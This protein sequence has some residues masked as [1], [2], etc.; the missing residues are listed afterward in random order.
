MKRIV[1]TLPLALALGACIAPPMESDEPTASEADELTVCPA[2]ATVSGIDTSHWQGVIDWSKVKAS[3][4]AFAIARVSD[5]VKY[6]DKNFPTDWPAIKAAGL[7]RGAYQFFRPA[8][9]PVAQADLLIQRLQQYGPLGPGDLPA[10]LDVETAD[11]MPNA[12]VRQNM[13]IWLDRVELHTGK[14]PIV[15]TAA[16]MSSVV[17]SGFS[18]YPLWVA[19]YG[20]NCPQL[21]S[22][23]S[24]WSIWQS[25]STGSVPGIAGNVDLDVFNGSLA[26]LQAFAAGGGGGVSWSCANS[27]YQGQQYWTCNSGDRY[28]C[29]SGVPV[30]DDCQ[31]GCLS[32]PVGKN[33]L[34][35]SSA[36]GWSCANSSYQNQQYWTCSGGSLHRCTNGAPEKVTCPSGCAVKPLG[37]NDV[38]N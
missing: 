38:C 36:P 3:G 6:P 10:V 20:V 26:D 17:G 19:N 8:Q 2:G 1:A 33:D 9:D 28:Q 11:G 27:S 24:Q 13:Q 22:G 16:F 15:Y 25:S 14:R 5:G 21:P 23:W 32:Q 37:T 4:K 34:C 30:K 31:V 29:Q 35:I 7:I 12:T 18:S